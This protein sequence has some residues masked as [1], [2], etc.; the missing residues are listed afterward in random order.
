MVANYRAFLE[1]R[2]AVKEKKKRG[3]QL[4][5]DE[6]ALDVIELY[7]QMQDWVKAR[8]RAEGHSPE[9]VGKTG[10]GRRD[11]RPEPGTH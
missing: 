5:A 9:E 3:E 2:R 7:R 10:S 8:K 4:T 1:Q 6:Q 11:A